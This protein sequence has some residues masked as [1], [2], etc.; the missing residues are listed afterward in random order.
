M[1]FEHILLGFNKGVK[2]PRP[3]VEKHLFGD[4]PAKAIRLGSYRMP[5]ASWI[6]LGVTECWYSRPRGARPL[7][8]LWHKPLLRQG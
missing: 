8:H 6:R 1:F 2:A 3:C 5:G 7:R 4:R